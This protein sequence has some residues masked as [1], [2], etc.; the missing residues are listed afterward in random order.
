MILRCVKKNVYEGLIRYI[1]E[2]GIHNEFNASINFNI[3]VN[4]DVFQL[5]IY[6]KLPTGKSIY[7]YFRPLKCSV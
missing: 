4:N 6:P 7:A 2:N 5:T 1:M 3:P